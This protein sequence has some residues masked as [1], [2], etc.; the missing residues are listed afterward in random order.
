M[1]FGTSWCLQPE[2]KGPPARSARSQPRER[3]LVPGCGQ[4]GLKGGGFSPD[5]IVLMKKQD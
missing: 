1:T 4:P 5:S 3:P 2:L